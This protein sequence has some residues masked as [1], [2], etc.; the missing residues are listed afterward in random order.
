MP[1][2]SN[3]GTDS[4]SLETRRARSE[5]QR[6]HCGWQQGGDLGVA[7]WHC[8]AIR[9]NAVTSPRPQYSAVHSTLY[10]VLPPHGLCTV[11]SSRGGTR[12]APPTS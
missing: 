6:G 10:T 9:G 4:S 7:M 3:S 5:D 1:F 2:G 8:L 12:V 11:Y